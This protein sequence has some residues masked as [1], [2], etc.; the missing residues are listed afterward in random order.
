MVNTIPLKNENQTNFLKLIIAPAVGFEPTVNYFQDSILYLLGLS[1]FFDW[2]D[3]TEY[4]LASN[5]TFW[6]LCQRANLTYQISIDIVASLGLEPKLTE[7]NS[8]VLPLHYEALKQ[9]QPYCK[10]VYKGDY[11]PSADEAY[12]ST[13]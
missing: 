6:F 3:M 12:Q 2:F 4:H 5:K 7:S 13:T 1:G 10:L 8:V 9:F 11:S